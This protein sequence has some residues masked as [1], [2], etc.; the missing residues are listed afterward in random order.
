MWSNWKNDGCP[1]FK[2]PEGGKGGS[3][4]TGSNAGKQNGRSEE[5]MPWCLAIAFSFPIFR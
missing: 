3:G 4:G 1:E 2:K 5:V